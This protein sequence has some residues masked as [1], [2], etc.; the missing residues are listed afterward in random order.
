MLRSVE[1]SA[2]ALDTAASLLLIFSDRAPSATRG[3]LGSIA[4]ALSPFDYP[5]ELPSY[6]N[7]EWPPVEQLMEVADRA[8]DEQSWGSDQQIDA[9]NAF[10]AMLERLNPETFN[11]SSEYADW[12]LKAT[13]QEMVTRGFELALPF[14]P[15]DAADA[16]R[17]WRMRQNLLSREDATIL[18]NQEL[19]TEGKTPCAETCDYLQR[20]A[21][22]N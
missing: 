16:L 7:S 2:E 15:D 8:I 21:E 22:G 11:E 5:L 1:A 6:I 3:E 12:C 4:R 14:L 17:L 19:H 13:S 18:L 20:I 9:A 10:A